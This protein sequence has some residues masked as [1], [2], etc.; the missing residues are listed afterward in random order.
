MLDVVKNVYIKVIKNDKISYFYN[1]GLFEIC[2]VI[3]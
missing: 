3:S 2:E 1:K